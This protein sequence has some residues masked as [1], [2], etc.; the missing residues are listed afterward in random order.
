MPGMN[1]LKGING[2]NGMY[3][4]NGMHGINGWVD[5]CSSSSNNKMTEMMTPNTMTEMPACGQ[6]PTGHPED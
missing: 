2:M 1:G 4:I 3:G 5:G 6:K